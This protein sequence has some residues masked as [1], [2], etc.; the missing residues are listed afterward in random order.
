MNVFIF[1][2]FFLPSLPVNSAEL[3]C[4]AIEKNIDGKV[5]T[6]QKLKKEKT[7][8]PNAEL[9]EM[10]SIFSKFPHC[11]LLEKKMAAYQDLIDLK[12][13]QETDYTKF[14]VPEE[15][16]QEVKLDL[17]NLPK[18]RNQK[19]L[20]W[21][22]AWPA[23]ALMSYKVGK[24]LSAYDVALQSKNVEMQPKA[25]Y[26]REYK[27]LK[28][29]GKLHEIV[30]GKFSEY[31]SYFAL[32]SIGEFDRGVCLES[33]LNLFVNNWAIQSNFFRELIT[34]NI[35]MTELLCQYKSHLTGTNFSELKEIGSILDKLTY[36][37]KASALI[38]L[39]CSEKRTKIP[40][41][42]KT[43]ILFR[44][45]SEVKGHTNRCPPEHHIYQLGQWFLRR[46]RFRRHRR[47]RY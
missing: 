26:F 38:E 35:T 39:A 42:E 15:K 11:K 16:C 25:E 28:E 18:N 3:S 7:E 46:Q 30:D 47:C 22:W 9:A 12:K 17:S 20:P 34:K 14:D 32:M 4:Q 19:R 41:L 44:G 5:A 40:D 31:S 33:D 10:F 23:T 27:R 45:Q 6:L 37:N 21:C 29:E 8:I 1:A 36:A 43:E 2:L 13:Y 24:P